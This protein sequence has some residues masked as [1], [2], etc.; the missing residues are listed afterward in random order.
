MK[1]KILTVKRKLILIV[2]LCVLLVGGACGTFFAVQATSSPKP[3]HTIVIDAG[4]GGK[5]GGAVGKMTEVTESYLN[6]QY[7][8]ALKDVCQEFGFKVVLTRS[9]MNGLYSPFA[10]N[11]KKSEMEKRR[12]IIE[13][14]NPDLV[15]SVHMNS[16]SSSS[17]C[18]ANVF[19]A[20][21]SECGKQ[22]A[23]SVSNMLHENIENAHKTAQIGDY[24]IL[25]CTDNPSILLECGFLSNPEEEVLLQDKE[26]MHKFCYNV[27][28]GIL[29]Y[30]KT[31]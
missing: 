29:M 30:Y 14:S 12:Q 6:L 25:N 20:E 21:G 16:F 28:C 22:L 4:H 3:V 19:Y 2:L 15:V 1:I 23:E 24:Y 26:Y 10:T 27:L 11:K 17:S 7:A 8:L 9:D 18:G 31:A 5:D 13:K